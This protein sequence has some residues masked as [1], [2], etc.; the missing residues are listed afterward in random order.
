MFDS[1]GNSWSLIK[2]SAKVLDAD[3]EL[4]IFP[5]IS[6]IAVLLLTA[7]FFVPM[8][9]VG[10]FGRVANQGLQVVDYLI[11]FLF[12]LIQYLLI[13]FSNTALVGAAMIRI[14]GGDP[15][16]RDG[17][18][19]A[20]D[21]FTSIFF[22]A[23]IA[24][25][26]GMLLSLIKEK[27]SVLSNIV[28]SLIGFVWNVATFLVVPVLA[29]EDVGPVEAIKRSVGYLKKTWGEQLVGSFS[30]GLVFNF[31]IFLVMGAG[32]LMIVLLINSSAQVWAFVSVGVV[33]IVFILGISLISTTLTG[34]Y[35]AAVYQ[36]A[37]TGDAGSFFESDA[38]QNAFQPA[39]RRKLI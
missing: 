39:A 7:V 32:A 20:S 28:V 19:I 30:I 17:L 14:R 25:T 10:Y 31:L 38:V 35:T 33:A 18:R 27:G 15:T 2:S 23:L 13:F 22:Y 9:L 5:I 11:L 24:S 16:I 26:V 12:Y 37:A 8:L 29:V 6:S 36:Y 3:R 21:R 4:L 1:I 34:I